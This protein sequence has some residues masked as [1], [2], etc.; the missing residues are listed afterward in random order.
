MTTVSMGDLF[1]GGGSDRWLNLP[2]AMIDA[3]H[4]IDL[5][6]IGIGSATPYPVGS[7]CHDAPD[8][9]RVKWYW[10]SI[11][12]SMI[13]TCMGHLLPIAPG[14]KAADPAIQH[15][16]RCCCRSHRKQPPHD[17]R[18]HCCHGSSDVIPFV[19]GGD[20]SVPIPVLDA[21]ADTAPAPIS[22]FQ[23]DAHIDWRDKSTGKSSAFQYAPCQRDGSYRQNCS[24]GGKGDRFA[25]SD[26]QDA[27]DYGV[28]FH[29]MRMLMQNG[30]I[31]AAIASLPE[32]VPVYIAWTSTVL[33][34]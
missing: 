27:L 22:I 28:D 32:G 24:G 30:G 33:I 17:P 6:V 11:L 25:R 9:I 29:T 3:L 23:I 8:A 34:R 16:R 1:G 7:Y 14:G 10:P 31:D 13:L 21:Y 20:D 26:V 18:F 19:L 2:A 4:D 15:C 12:T 5:G